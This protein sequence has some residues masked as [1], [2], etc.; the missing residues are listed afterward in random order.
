M[1]KK[2]KMLFSRTF[3]FHFMEWMREQKNIRT[4]NKN[5]FIIFKSNTPERFFFQ[6][7]TK[8]KPKIAFFILSILGHPK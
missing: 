7:Q 8:K 3:L 1:K 5:K 2:K 4:K 6:N